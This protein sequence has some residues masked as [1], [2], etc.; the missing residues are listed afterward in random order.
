MI[1]TELKIEIENY[2]FNIYNYNFILKFFSLTS[3]KKNL[4]Y[5]LQN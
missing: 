4:N 3:K 1:L 2:L 5:Y